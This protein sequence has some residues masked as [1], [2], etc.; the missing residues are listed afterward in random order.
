MYFSILIQKMLYPEKYFKY[1]FPNLEYNLVQAE[2]PCL[3][4][5]YTDD[6]HLNGDI[7]LSSRQLV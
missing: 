2:P 5:N 4:G 3:I 1:L 6:S 7:I